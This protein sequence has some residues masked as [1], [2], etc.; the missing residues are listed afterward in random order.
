MRIPVVLGKQ[1]HEDI[2][3]IAALTHYSSQDIMRLALRIGLTDLLSTGNDLP[4]LVKKS[5]DE[6]GASFAAFA[7]RAKKIQEGSFP[8]LPIFAPPEAA[9][10]ENRQTEEA[11]SEPLPEGRPFYQ[12]PD[13]TALVAEDPPTGTTADPYRAAAKDFLQKNSAASPPPAPRST[14]AASHPRSRGP[15]PPKRADK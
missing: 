7:Q 2:N 1:L 14:T 12:R 10:S 8:L 15:Q 11:E 3:S 13:L 6:L 5:A 4:S 9:D